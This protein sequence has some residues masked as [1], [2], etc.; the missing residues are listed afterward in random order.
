MINNNF[1]D[2]LLQFHNNIRT[3]N[4]REF[5][6]QNIHYL[7]SYK[8]YLEPLLIYIFYIRDIHKGKGCRKQFY[9]ILVELYKQLP[10]TL[11]LPLLSLIPKYGSFKD[12]NY[13]WEIGD[14]ENIPELKKDI[15]NLYIL[16]LNKDLYTVQYTNNTPSLAAKWAPRESGH[17]KDMARQLALDIFRLPTLTNIK[18]FKNYRKMVSDINKHLQTTE[19][20]MTSNNWNNIQP[21]NVPSICFK[22]N[23][24]SFYNIDNN[25]I[26]KSNNVN[27]ITCCNN[28]INTRTNTTHLSPVN[29]IHQYSTLVLNNVNN[30]RLEN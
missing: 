11:I 12:L 7:L 14:L 17:F 15:I 8:N 13:L 19:T 24:K 1:Y 21:N 30:S 6:Q 22:K 10:H 28:F 25:N 9:W 16:H 2:S 27:R 29:I 3:N 23:F 5:I 18:K 4:T 20:F 26:Q